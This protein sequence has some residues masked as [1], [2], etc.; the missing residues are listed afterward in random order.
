M[1]Y[2]TLHITTAIVLSLTFQKLTCYEVNLQIILTYTS[3]IQITRIMTRQTRWLCCMPTVLDANPMG[4][5][6]ASKLGNHASCGE[7]GCLKW[8][9]T[10]PVVGHL[11]KVID[12]NSGDGTHY[13]VQVTGLP[14]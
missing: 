9:I 10:L 5:L 4:I 8:I 14:T 7:S 6:I 2:R 3:L 1:E 13:A 12:G 11:L